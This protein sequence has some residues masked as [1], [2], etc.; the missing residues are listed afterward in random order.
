MAEGREFGRGFFPERG[1][2]VWEWALVAVVAVVVSLLA[3]R[4]LV[5]RA[6]ARSRRRALLEEKLRRLWQTRDTL[7]HHESWAKER[8]DRDEEKDMRREVRSTDARIREVNA[9]LDEMDGKRHAGK[10]A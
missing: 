1:W 5:E 4:P 7:A 9:E 2:G 3:A 6:L 10:K 8:G